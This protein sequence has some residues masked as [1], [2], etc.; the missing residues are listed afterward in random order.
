MMKATMAALTTARITR[1]KPICLAA[2]TISLPIT[3]PSI[4]ARV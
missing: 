1:N 3:M 4:C 2:V